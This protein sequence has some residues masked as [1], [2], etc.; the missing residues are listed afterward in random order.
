MN[1]G[2]PDPEPASPDYNRPNEPWVCG[3]ASE[4]NPCR[5]GPDRKGHCR[6]APE[7]TPALEKKYWE[8]KGRWKCTRAG[9][10]CSDGPGPDGSCGRPISRCAPQ[11]TLRW[12][13][14]RITVAVVA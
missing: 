8:T 1:E 10:E 5:L 12:W 11:P 3:H 6:A 7:C 13:R 9:G 4:G 2:L 14:G